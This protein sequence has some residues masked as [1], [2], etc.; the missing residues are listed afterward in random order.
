MV[1]CCVVCHLSPAASFGVQICQPLPSWGAS[2][3]L[4]P[5]GRHPLS[6]TIPS[7]CLSLF[8]RASIAFAAPIAGWLLRSPPAQQHKDHITKLKTFPV[9]TSWTYF[10]LLRVST[11]KRMK[12]LRG[13]HFFLSSYDLIS[14]DSY[15]HVGKC[16]GD[17]IPRHDFVG[18]KK[19]RL[20]RM[21]P[22]CRADI[23]KMLATDTN[24]CRLG[25][26]ANRHKSQHCQ[27]SSRPQFAATFD[28]K[29]TLP[30]A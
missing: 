9:S 6:L 11:C 18:K 23:V 10:D 20:K 30:A 13:C 15:V 8:Y 4:F 12:N 25:G 1:G 29:H 24:V 27:P 21:S 26:V 16:V 28:C 3:T 5:L 14:N 2:L 22:T 17:T 19:G 7:L